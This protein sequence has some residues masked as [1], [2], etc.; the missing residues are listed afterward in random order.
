[1][2]SVRQWTD[3]DNDEG[4][5]LH[6]CG[7]CIVEREG[8]PTLQAAQAWIFEHAKVTQ[9]KRQ[10]R[11]RFLEGCTVIM[12]AFPALMS[13]TGS[14]T[15]IYNLLR[16]E[17]AGMW[18]TLSRHIWRKR[19]VMEE[20]AEGINREHKLINELR[21]CTDPV[22]EVAIVEELE[23]L[24]EAE[25]CLAFKDRPNQQAYIKACSYSDVRLK[26]EDSQG[27]VVAII[28][29]YY[30]CLGKNGDESECLMMIPSKDWD[31]NGLD[32]IACKRWYCTSTKHYKKY[33]AGWGQIV[34]VARFVKGCWERYY[35][36]AKVPD[37]DKEDIRAM[38]VEERI[39]GTTDSPMDVYR[40]LER[41]VPS[42]DD[43]VVPAENGLPDSV[44][45][46][47]RADLDGMPWFPWD[48]I[49]GMVGY[50]PASATAKKMAARLR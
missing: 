20:W 42:V 37:W 6:T 23:H 26:V 18:M 4:H 19:Q 46:R 14:K 1:M 28:S 16:G 9:H 24:Q 10:R 13:R 3:E 43:L 25:R 41:L 49:Y 36:R 50:E 11:D 8:L 33:Q 34:I 17:F 21:D 47:S 7:K 29:S 39:A 32:P 40:K 31:T 38:D 35:M 15:K 48:Q 12:E 5:W 44:R 27:N 22:R 30:I 2:E 45:L